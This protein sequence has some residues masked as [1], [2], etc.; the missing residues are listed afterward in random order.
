MLGV[1]IPVL[2]LSAFALPLASLIIKR[3]RFYDIYTIVFTS[4]TLIASYMIYEEVYKLGTPIVYAFGGWPPPLGIVYEVDGFNSILGLFTSAVM[5]AIALYSIWYTEHMDEPVWYYT[6]L[7]GLETGL[8]G[9]LYT[10]DAFN[11]FVMLE[12]LSIS[13]YALVAY[14]RSRPQA[15]EAAIKYAIVG[16]VATTL[17]F[18]SLVF[19]Y[20]SYGTLNMA[21]ISMKSLGITRYT[22][23]SDGVYGS[24]LTASSVALALALWTFTFKSALFPN[25]FWLPDAHPEA[26]T[27][28]SAALS[29]LVV[30]IGVYAVA[31]FLYTIFGEYSIV[32]VDGFRDIVLYAL[33]V[34]GIASGF[35]AALLMIVQ[36]DIKRL[37]AYSTISHIGLIYM[38]LAIGFSSTPTEVKVIGLTAMIYHIINHGVAK[39]LLF[40]SSGVYIMAS[41]TRDLDKMSGVGRAYPLTTIALIMGFLQLMGFI[42]FGGFFSKLL[43]YQAYIANGSVLP[44][45]M[46][47]VI[48][49]I[50]LLGYIKV[51]YA[52]IFAPPAKEYTYRVNKGIEILLVIMGIAC[53]L[54]GIF[55]PYIIDELKILIQNSLVQGIDKYIDAFLRTYN[56]LLR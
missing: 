5:F 8:L 3:K 6:L 55:S 45:V 13:A 20:A 10:G 30:N 28:V 4:F 1:I 53:L 50:S 12:V 25:H 14:Y 39:A 19:I 54:L 34:L 41:G 32:G 15:I 48:S 9:C 56:E 31:R 52:T 24:L 51:M 42:P 23:I 7:L 46:V 11:L 33:L 36:N 29:G 22:V 18:L 40:M 17:Y 26:P 2:A 21:D 38:G 16:A 43:L 37:L 47:I 35:I 49:A 44:A 27:P